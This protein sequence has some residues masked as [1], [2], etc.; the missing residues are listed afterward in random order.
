MIDM[1]NFN[2]LSYVIQLEA[3]GVSRQQAQVHAHMLQQVY[4]EE[5][6]QYATKADLQCLSNFLENK[7]SSEIADVKALINECKQDFAE[8]KKDFAECKKDFAECKQDIAECKKDFAECKQGFAE[9]RADIA[10]IK[11]SHKYL[12]WIGGGIATM[13]ASAIGMCVSMFLY[14]LK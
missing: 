11:I 3:A 10:S 9:L 2:S 12:I 7:I 14:S 13:C 6:S 8:C 1:A 4:D 5:H